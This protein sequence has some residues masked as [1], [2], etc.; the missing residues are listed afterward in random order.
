VK[1]YILGLF[2]TAFLAVSSF[3][4]EI[5]NAIFVDF[6]STILGV[7]IGGFGV[8][9]GYEHGLTDNFSTLINASY[10]G[11]T[12]KGQGLY[13]TEFLGI[14]AGLQARYYPLGSSIR[15]W[16]VGILGNYSYFS[17]TYGDKIESN[18]FEAGALSGWKFVFESSGF[19]LEPGLGY[20]LV[21]QDIK[22]P[23]GAT[24]IPQTSGFRLW[25]G[26]GWA[27]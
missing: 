6:G 18:V 22:T 7:L 27:F 25:F 1:K 9:L 2:L 23:V 26:M 5:P 21:F 12:I 24:S 3:G 19:F 13:D 11:T 4:Q 15:R 17:I 10:I 20:T 16:F 8:G 14:S